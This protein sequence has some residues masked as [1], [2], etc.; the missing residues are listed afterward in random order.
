MPLLAPGIRHSVVLYSETVAM[1]STYAMDVVQ[2][3]TDLMQALA[4]YDYS[5]WSLVIGS[6]LFLSFF[7]SLATKLMQPTEDEPEI[8]ILAPAVLRRTSLAP[9]AATLKSTAAKTRDTIIGRETEDDDQQPDTSCWSA[10]LAAVLLILVQWYSVLFLTSVTSTNAVVTAKPETIDSYA[11]L[12]RA[13]GLRPMWLKSMSTFLEF[14]GADP[15][16]KA[17]E[18]W[19]KAVRMGIEE[20]LVS[21]SDWN[22]LAS[23]KQVWLAPFFV[24]TGTQYSLCANSYAAELV[25]EAARKS[26]VKRDESARERL[27]TLMISSALDARVSQAVDKRLRRVFEMTYRKMALARASRKWRMTQETEQECSSNLVSA[28]DSEVKP[29]LMIQ[30]RYLLLTWVTGIAAAT[31]VHV[32]QLVRLWRVNLANRV[33]IL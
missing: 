23:G 14:R 28:P 19:D 31:A 4:A 22:A 25:A 27:S 8:E 6:I 24:L 17:R 32:A 29:I 16:T 5:I 15:G 7:A 10:S 11:D 30:M 9:L 1:L 21:Y 20:S 26:L 33:V 18:V 13:P 3:S 12:I 2:E